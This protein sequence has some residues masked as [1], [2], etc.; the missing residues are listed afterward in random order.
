MTSTPFDDFL[1][2]ASRDFASHRVI[3]FVGESGSGK[4]TAIRFLLER[5]PDFQ[6]SEALVVDEARLI[7]LLQLWQPIACGTKA[8]VA[9]HLAAATLRLLLPFPGVAVFRTDRDCGKIRR[10]LE[11]RNVAA[12]AAAVQAY[13]RRFGATY[14]DVDL[15]LER[16]PGRSFDAALGCF[17][18][19]CTLQRRAQAPVPARCRAIRR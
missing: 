17:E 7:D 8:L 18:H 13:V 4:S 2:L 9:S 1:G 5:H 6:R 11:R 3:A 15:I 10:Y 16:F 19:L 12:T 14:T